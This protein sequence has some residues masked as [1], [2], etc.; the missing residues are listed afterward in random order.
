MTCP[1]CRTTFRYDPERNEKW[2]VKYPDWHRAT[3]ESEEKPDL[4]TPKTTNPAPQKN[5][6][7]TRKRIAGLAMVL[8]FAIAVALTVVSIKP[9]KTDEKVNLPRSVSLPESEP[10]AVK[11]VDRV[12][13]GGDSIGF[14]LEN[15]DE[16]VPAIFPAGEGRLTVVNETALD[17]VVKLV[18]EGKGTTLLRYWFIESKKAVVLEDLGPCGCSLYF[19]LGKEWDHNTRKFRLN[20]SYGKYKEP[21]TFTETKTPDGLRSQNYTVHFAGAAGSIAQTHIV[22]ETT[23]NELF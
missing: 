13:R 2:D 17:A 12:R 23:F 1:S 19:G 9:A 8:V 5:E 11:E 6:F 15:G 18:E 22:D 4:H 3:E 21:L 16:L 20:R 14:P 7:L 10:L